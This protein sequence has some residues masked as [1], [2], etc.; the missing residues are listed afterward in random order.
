MFEL[1][2]QLLADEER[3]RAFRD[4][5]RQTVTPEDVV[6]DLGTGTGVLAFF[7]CEAG[8]RRVYALEQQHT[9]D[10]AVMLARTFGYAERLTVIHARS[11]DVELPEPATVLISET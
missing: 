5:I 4:A 10:A 8:A 7:A 11:H 2:R 6:L 3:T 1:H 9:A